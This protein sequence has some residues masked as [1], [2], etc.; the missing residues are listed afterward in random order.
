MPHTGLV[1]Y[2][3]SYYDMFNAVLGAD[4]PAVISVG[5]KDG[6]APG[7]YANAMGA[8][9]DALW[10]DADL[11]AQYSSLAYNSLDTQYWSDEGHF[12]FPEGVTP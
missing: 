4:A 3:Q 2:V 8:V 5:G 6:W 7:A 9:Q 12:W 10:D 1:V 11:Y